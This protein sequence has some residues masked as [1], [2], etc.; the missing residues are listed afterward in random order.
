M[1]HFLGLFGIIAIISCSTTR[2][3]QT[4]SLPEKETEQV[5]N[6][7]TAPAE[8]VKD[9]TKSTTTSTPEEK[10]TEEASVPT[11]NSGKE[12][13]KVE[14]INTTEKNYDEIGL[15][16]WYGKQFQGKL[17]ASG[18][19]YD[20]QKLTAAHRTLPFG[21]L[22]KVTNLE[23]KKETTVKIIDRGPFAEGRVIDVSEKAAEELAFKENGVTRVGIKMV[24]GG[25]SEI[26]SEDELDDFLKDDLDDEDDDILED[27]GGEEKSTK[28]ATSET[29]EQPSTKEEPAT[30]EEPKKESVKKEEPKKE[31]PKA[32]S[33]EKPSGYTVQLGIFKEEQNALRFKSLEKRLG[34]KL[35]IYK[36]KEGLCVQIGDF[37]NRKDARNVQKEVRKTGAKSFVP[38]QKV[39]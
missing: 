25:D 18:E 27:A 29:K 12:A 15:S 17:T 32:I 11:N 2:A 1:R 5:T 28:K 3:N 24:K 39:Q 33:N 14:E 10:K 38:K 23:N 26:G 4:Q 19:T 22:V 34:K 31:E 7:E 37:A 9:E 36:R 21:S 30:K 16:S 6:R 13:A 20:N 8:P 35:F